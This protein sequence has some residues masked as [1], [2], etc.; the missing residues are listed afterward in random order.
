[1]TCSKCHH[2]IGRE[3]NGS[4]CTHTGCDCKLT[5]DQ[6]TGGTGGGTDGETVD[7]RPNKSN[8]SAHAFWIIVSILLVLA[9]YVAYSEALSNQQQFS[10]IL[11]QNVT[12]IKSPQNQTTTVVTETPTTSPLIPTYILIWGFIGSSVYSLKVTTDKIRKGQFENKNIPHLTIRLF[13]G[14]ALAVVIFFIL[15]TGIFFGLTIDF[16]KVQPT[17]ISYVYAAIA[18]LSGYFVNDVISMF[19]SIMTGLLRFKPQDTASTS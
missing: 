4:G 7:G 6:L 3:H 14:P 2:D 13:I 1:M 19:S 18:F 8:R 17:L 5:L 10:N 16:S 9:L 12:T 11:S 15:I